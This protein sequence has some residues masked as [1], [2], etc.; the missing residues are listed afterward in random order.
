MADSSSE[1]R[2]RR[3][4]EG[5][6]VVDAETFIAAPFTAAIC[7]EDGADVIKV[8]Q[9]GSGDPMRSFG[10]V[11]ANG[12]SLNW[13]SE[14]RNKRSVTFDL[15]SPKGAELFR[16][17]AT[18]SDVECENFRPGTFE[19]WGLGYDRLSAGN[20]GLILLRISAFGQDGPYRALPGFAR[21]AH[22]GRSQLPCRRARRSSDRARLD[23]ARRPHLRALRRHWRHDGAKHRD[24]SGEGQ[25]IDVALYESIFRVLDEIAPA[26]AMFGKVRQPMGSAA[27]NVCPHNHYST[28]DDKWV[29]IACTSDKMFERLARVMECPELAAPARWGKSERRMAE[30]AAVDAMVEKW[31]RSHTLAQVLGLASAGEVPCGAL[32]TIADVFADPRF[33]AREV[34]QTVDVPQVGPV[35]VPGPL[36][37]LSRSAGRLDSLGPALGSANEDVFCGLLALTTDELRSLSEE[38]VI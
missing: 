24:L 9:P 1:S 18:A 32:N 31:T 20:R 36:P 7:G 23:L 14:G 21:I 25:V 35:V 3:P 22:G 15:R 37:K 6:R 34:L 11:T 8:E 4:L 27:P 30:A 17:L 38:G 29:A 5:I 33:A 28:R 26:F 19:R 12:D 10:S 13:L 2:P 16:R